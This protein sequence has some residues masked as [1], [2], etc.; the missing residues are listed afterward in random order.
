VAA[1]AG[2]A[3]SAASRAARSSE[4]TAK[5][6]LACCCRAARVS[7]SSDGPL[8]GTTS[9]VGAGGAIW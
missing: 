7:K 3:R 9:A 8:A 2:M 6:R 4:G 5:P 1:A